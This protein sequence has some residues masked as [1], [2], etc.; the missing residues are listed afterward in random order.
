MPGTQLIELPDDLINCRNR[1]LLAL[2]LRILG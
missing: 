2:K 1:V